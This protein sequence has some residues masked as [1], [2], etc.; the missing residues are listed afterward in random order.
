LDLQLCA[1]VFA[2]TGQDPEF[3]LSKTQREKM[4]YLAAISWF[5]EKQQIEV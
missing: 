4:F 3:I 1:Y 2:Q 5:N